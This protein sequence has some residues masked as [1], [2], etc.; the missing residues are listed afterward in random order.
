MLCAPFRFPLEEDVEPL[1]TLGVANTYRLQDF[2]PAAFE[3]GQADVRWFWRNDADLPVTEPAA[4][5]VRFT[6]QGSEPQGIVFRYVGQRIGEES[7]TTVR[8]R[9]RGVLQS[10]TS[11]APYHVDTLAEL[12]SIATGFQNE[13]LAAPLAVAE[14]LAAHYVLIA[15]IDASPTASGSWQLSSNDA[16][17]PE[18]SSDDVV[19]HGFLPIGNCGTNGDLP[20]D[21]C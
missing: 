10:G 3:V 14:S 12:Q 16:G 2:D 20:R 19:Q 4:G 13:V 15:D 17:T 1:V 5:A 6:P 8:F 7:F 21:R 11:E 9:V 18:D